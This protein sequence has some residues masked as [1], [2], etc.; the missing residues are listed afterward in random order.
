M[1]NKAQWEKGVDGKRRPKCMLFT[2]E[3]KFDYEGAE[4][5]W[6]VYNQAYDETL[7]FRETV[8]THGFFLQK[9]PDRGEIIFPWQLRRVFIDLQKGGWKE[10]V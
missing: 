10:T 1:D 8:L 4:S 2:V 3:I 6:F 5:R 7:L 9:G